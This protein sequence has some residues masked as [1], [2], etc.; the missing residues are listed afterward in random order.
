MSGHD[1]SRAAGAGNPERLELLRD[2]EIRRRDKLKARNS[3]GSASVFS[4]PCWLFPISSSLP[5]VAE[6]VHVLDGGFEDESLGAPAD[7]ERIALESFD[8][9]IQREQYR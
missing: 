6:L 7:L 1:F 5:V 4:I 8:A 2:V 3:V 9:A